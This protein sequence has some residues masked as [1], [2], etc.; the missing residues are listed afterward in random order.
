MCKLCDKV[1]AVKFTSPNQYFQC[2]GY[3]KSLVKE[4]CLKIVEQTCD[5]EKVEKE[6]GCWFDDI[7]EH[8]LKCVKCGKKF[9]CICD[10]YHGH[11]SFKPL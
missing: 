7:I 3:I 6:N 2:L 1:E 11:G 8:K 9:L 5:L 4:N 10:T